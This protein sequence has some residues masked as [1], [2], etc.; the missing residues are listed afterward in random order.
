MI[1]NTST[2]NINPRHHFD[3]DGDGDGAYISSENLLLLETGVAIYTIPL[4]IDLLT[5]QFHVLTYLSIST[6]AMCSN[7]YAINKD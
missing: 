3:F 5:S 4:L 6:V 7:Q 1:P 2:Y